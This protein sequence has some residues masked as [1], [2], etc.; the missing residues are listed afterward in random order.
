V[1]ELFTQYGYRGIP[2]WV[3]LSLNNLTPCLLS[4]QIVLNIQQVTK[5]LKPFTL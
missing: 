2:Y 4:R 5:P 1:G 3:F